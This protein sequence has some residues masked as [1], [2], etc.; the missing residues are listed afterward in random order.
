MSLLKKSQLNKPAGVAQSYQ[1]QMFE[2]YRRD[3]SSVDQS[4]KD[5]FEGS[6]TQDIVGKIRSLQSQ[7][8]ASG[9]HDMLEA[10]SQGSKI[11]SFIRSI[12]SYGH[13]NADLDPLKQSDDFRGT[14][15]RDTTLS[16]YGFTE[17]DLDNKF[18]IDIPEMGGMLGEKK[19]WTLR[20][21]E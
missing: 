9:S 15:R 8:G 13:L 3:P 20:E 4:W 11:M 18:H 7:S 14:K 19:D 12:M 16:H 10:Q 6:G 17:A 5:F 1:D 21:L 2:S